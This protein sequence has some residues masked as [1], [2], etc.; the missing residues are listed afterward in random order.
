MVKLF[1][2]M[3]SAKRLICAESGATVKV[4]TQERRTEC[5]TEVRCF[6]T[7]NYINMMQEAT[8]NGS[9]PAATQLV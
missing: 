1:Y 5:G 6:H 2:G 4:G 9:F 7:G 3:G 8:I